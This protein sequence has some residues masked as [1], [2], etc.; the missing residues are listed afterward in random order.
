MNVGNTEEMIITV[1]EDPAGVDIII[2]LTETGTNLP[3]GSLRVRKEKGIS[4]LECL[5]T[6]YKE[7]LSNYPEF[8]KERKMYTIL[9]NAENGVM[10][11][12]G[13]T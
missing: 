13:L 10:K 1:L 3:I 6:V 11:Y 8:E 4:F 5:T 12:M 2:N 7:V 9:K